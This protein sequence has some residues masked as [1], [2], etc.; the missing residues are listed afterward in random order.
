MLILNAIRLILLFCTF[1]PALFLDLVKFTIPA[2]PI[3]R[4]VCETQWS[5]LH[6]K[7]L[8]SCNIVTKVKVFQ[9]N[10]LVSLE[11]AIS[12]NIHLKYIIG[13]IITCSTHAPCIK[14]PR[15][16]L[17]LRPWTVSFSYSWHCQTHL[18]MRICLKPLKFVDFD[19]AFSTSATT[20]Q[21]DEM[22]SCCVVRPVE[23]LP[24]TYFLLT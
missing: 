15:D 24:N 6:S 10:K 12:T 5:S 20:S 22:P 7:S 17:Q 9:L 3:Q 11:A 23:S 1:C 18:Q 2:N 8:F 16:Q 13:F 19:G 14:S 4:F 21:T